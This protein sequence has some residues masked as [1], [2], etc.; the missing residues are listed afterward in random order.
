[1]LKPDF[2]NRD[3]KLVAQELLGKVLVRRVGN[4][5]LKARIV[6]TE[7]YY[8]SEDPASRA[9]RGQTAMNKPMF[10]HS[11]KT[12]VYMVH[13]NWLLNVVTEPHG[14][15]AAVLIRA[16][17][18]LEGHSHMLKNRRK[19]NRKIKHHHELCSGPGKLTQALG[20][21]KEHTGTDVTNT[22]SEIHIIDDNFSSFELSSSKRIGVS[23]DLPENLRFFLKG[24]E[25]VSK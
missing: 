8:G 22:S 13:N 19:R 9:Y 3:T 2:F 14:V 20:I 4:K 11:G 1:M 16:L 18:P 6:E 25:F 15:S 21:L 10:G 24:N 17:E 5:V 23:A 12:F 7:A